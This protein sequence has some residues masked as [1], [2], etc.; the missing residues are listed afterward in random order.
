MT[1]AG[2][3]FSSSTGVAIFAMDTPAGDVGTKPTI[4]ATFAGG[5]A[6]AS[7]LVQEI[8]GLAAGNTTAAMLDG[9]AVSAGFAASAS[10]AQPAYSST[11]SGEFL[12]SLQGDDGGPQVASQPAGYTLDANAVNN[13]SFANVC[14]AYKNSTGGAESGTWTF[15]GTTTQTALMVIAF[16]LPAVTSG[17][18]QRPQ[19][20][21]LKWRRL[22]RRPQVPSA[23]MPAPAVQQPLQFADQSGYRPRSAPHLPRGNLSGQAWGQGSQGTSFPLY[24]RQL[25]QRI[26]LRR[27]PG[28]FFTPGQFN[29]TAPQLPSFPRQALSRRILAVVRPARGQ[30]LGQSWGQGNQ[31]TSFP[32]DE[33]EG[34][35][36]PRGAPRISRG[37]F[38]NPGQWN[39]TAPQLPSFTRKTDGSRLALRRSRGIFSGQAWG[40]GNQGTQFP[41]FLHPVSRKL[42]SLGGRGRFLPV[43]GGNIQLPPPQPVARQMHAVPLRAPRGHFQLPGLSQDNRGISFPLFLRQ[44]GFSR[45]APRRQQGRFTGVPSPAAVAPV[46]QVIRGTAREF[47]RVS[48]GRFTSPGWGQSNQGNTFPLFLRQDSRRITRVPRGHFL[49]PGQFNSA[50][51]QLPS[52]TRARG[53]IALPVHRGAVFAVPARLVIAG[54]PQ[55]LVSHRQRITSV[56][57]GCEFARIPTGII[58]VFPPEFRTTRRYNFTRLDAAR[59]GKIIQ[60]VPFQAPAVTA[61]EFSLSLGIPGSRWRTGTP[62]TNWSTP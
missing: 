3:L 45:A 6:D 31:G 28:K 4:T 49:T 44:A 60:L 26:T 22:Y 46:P 43:P 48:R 47:L 61:P 57:R 33:R 20:G 23:V 55:L 25:Y 9:T 10:D 30:F 53:R 15:T 24:L 27:S 58:T 42:L 7:I 1:Q 12:V 32:L 34:G 16:K 50:A 29:Q 21:D 8:S 56:R 54:V 11:I 40:Q 62:R 39:E 52:F 38:F 59:H 5:S 14:P 19:P 36:S 37:H 18:P 51:P 35:S 41:S 17:I 2:F 13:N